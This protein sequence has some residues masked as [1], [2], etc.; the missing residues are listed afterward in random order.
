MAILAMVFHGLEAR[1]TFCGMG[2]LPMNVSGMGILPMAFH[3]LA[4]G[5]YLRTS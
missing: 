2:I 3:G 5:H 1:A 4:P